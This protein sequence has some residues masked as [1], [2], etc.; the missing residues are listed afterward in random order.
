[1]KIPLVDLSWQHREIAEEVQA[2][3][4]RVM[5]ASTFVL[6]PEVAAFEEAFASF[7][8]VSFCVGVAYYVLL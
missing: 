7:C 8:D 5:E 2:G 3:F 4:G 6:G 1:M